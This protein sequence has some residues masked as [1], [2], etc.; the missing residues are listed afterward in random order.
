MPSFDRIVRVLHASAGEEGKAA[1]SLRA[2]V[3]GD[4]VPHELLCPRGGKG[5][6]DRAALERCQQGVVLQLA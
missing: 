6:R 2:V 3:G 4:E 5:R 1:A